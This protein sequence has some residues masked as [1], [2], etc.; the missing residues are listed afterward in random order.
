MGHTS[1][2]KRIFTTKQRRARRKKKA[3]VM[4]TFPIFV[5]FVSSWFFFTMDVVKDFHWIKLEREEGSK[6]L[7]F[8]KP[9]RRF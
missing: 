6:F 9:Q 1:L 8:G 2:R 7:T 4:L 3:D 5:L